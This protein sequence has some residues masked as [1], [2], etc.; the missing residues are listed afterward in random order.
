MDGFS[1]IFK[2]F[3]IK[4][5]RNGQR[6]IVDLVLNGK[7]VIAILPTGGGKSLCFQ[8][9]TIA[10]KGLCIV[11]SPLISLMNDQVIGLKSKGIKAG[12]LHSLL[13]AEE[14]RLVIAEATSGE[15]YLLYMSP[16]RAQSDD[17]R[18]IINKRKPVLFAIDEAHCISQWGHDF[19]KEYNKL[20]FLKKDYPDIPIIALTASATPT[21][22]EDI[23]KQLNIEHAEKRVFG[24]YRPN[25]FYQVELFENDT[26]K[27]P[28]IIQAIGQFKTGRAIVYCS[29]RKSTVMI[30]GM[31]S[32]K[33]DNVDYYHAG[34]KQD[35]RKEKQEKY[36]KGDTRILVAT[37]AFGMGIDQPNV[38]LVVHYQMPGN[39]DAL[40]QEMG[41]AGRDGNEAT[42][43]LLF[44]K[45]DISL[46]S[47]FIMKSR[48]NPD[49]KTLK[50]GNLNHIIAYTNSRDCR[51]SEI[52][53]YYKDE[54]QIQSCGH[55]DS[56]DPDSYR[57]ISMTNKPRI[58]KKSSQMT[59][60]EMIFLALR[61]WRREQARKKSLPSFVICTDVSLKD[62]SQKLPLT[63]NELA[64]C[65]GFDEE[66]AL[67]HGEG[68]FN[69]LRKGIERFG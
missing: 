21:V 45:K 12:A 28:F 33:F 53:A 4:G 59:F 24:F 40:Y 55:C 68:I 10:Q 27:I 1:D 42:C 5:F 39:I 34:L 56:C 66:S 8:F 30:A 25:L 23:A 19:R 61:A 51:H 22:I 15:P 26:E 48:A 47:F 20:S 7:D 63:F 44:S 62:I 16:E 41:R 6:E 14:E 57:M 37:N 64:N 67:E 52:L 65:E 36:V 49:I 29:T 60:S 11:I 32:K 50:K 3:K 54:N 46:Q 58:Q 9:P 69:I 35:V 43:L 2:K 18:E 17:F 31:L 38:Y 13:K